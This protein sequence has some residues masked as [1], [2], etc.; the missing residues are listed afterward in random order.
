[1]PLVWFVVDKRA[2]VLLQNSI[3]NFSLPVGLRVVR[4][5]HSEFGTTKTEEF[6]PKVTNENWISVRDK[7]SWN[8]VVFA[9]YIQE[10]R[11]HFEGRV[12]G[13]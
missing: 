3:Q 9:N 8:A 12:I 5:A 7:A 6:S 2:Q 11:S 4:G 13:R 10:E 1:M